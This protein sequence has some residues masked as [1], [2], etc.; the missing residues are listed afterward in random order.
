MTKLRNS[1]PGRGV[2]S[3]IMMSM[4]ICAAG[5]G[6]VRVSPAFAQAQS[7]VE[8]SSLKTM[9]QTR[10]RNLLRSAA[11]LRVEIDEQRELYADANRRNYRR[12]PK[13]HL[14]EEA[15]DD[16]AKRLADVE[17]ELVAI[18]DEGRR[19]GALPGWFYEVELEFEAEKLAGPAMPDLDEESP[20][21]RSGG[22]NPLYEEERDDL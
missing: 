17:A 15:M 9:W 5:S 11:K 7:D 4:L 1:L 3:L 8:L 6:L 19:A 22:Q 10:Y 18:H 14:H 20:K 13:R 21:E 2:V 16:A 12:G